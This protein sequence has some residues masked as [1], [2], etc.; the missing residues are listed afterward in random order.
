MFVLQAESEPA[1]ALKSIMLNLNLGKPPDNIAPGLLFDKINQR[2]AEA[3]KRNG[4][5]AKPLFRP[6]K[7]LTAEQWAKI[8]ELNHELNAEYDLRRDMLITRLDVTVQ[9]F[10]WS[11][12]IKGKEDKMAE[13]YSNKR[14]ELDY[15]KHAGKTTDIAELLASREDIAII[16]KTSSAGVRANTQS[17]IQRHVIG[18]VPDRGGRAREHAPPP[19]EMPFF[20]QRTGG[21]GGG[22]FG[23][24]P[25]QQRNQHNNSQRNQS[26]NQQNQSYNN[27]GNSR[28]QGGWNQ[29]GRNIF[30]I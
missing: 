19:P 2:V 11:G 27:H 17:D 16:D 25:Q 21:P 7:P 13:N 24:K 10:H 15:L 22:G 28:V 5:V 14:K 6:T 26:N 3:V 9:S 12:N 23:Q 1:V 4:A 8:E 30:I 20:K 18:R 29:P